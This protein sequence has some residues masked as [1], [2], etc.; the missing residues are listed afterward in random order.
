VNVSRRW[1]EAFLR[2]ELEVHDLARRLAQ[3][4]APADA[5]EPLHA[6]L[7]DIVI[8]AVEEVRPHPN[9]DR[10]RLCTVNDGSADRR[11]VVCGAP[12]V[13]AGAKY[14][15][16]PV[17]STLPGGLV[18]EKRKIRGELSEGMLCSARELGL[19]EDHDGILTLETEAAPG[20][21]FL[22]TMGL[23]DERLVLDTSPV[24]PDLLGH[25]GIARELAAAYR[26]TFRLPEIPAEIMDAP[27]IARA[28]ASAGRTGG[29]A[30]VIEAGSSCARFTGAVIRGVRVSPSPAWLRH[31]LE[32]VGV[33]SINNVVDA[34]NYGP[35]RSHRARPEPAHRGAAPHRHPHASRGSRRD[36]GC[37]SRARSG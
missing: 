31:R 17:G 5:I 8:A 4:G 12:N 1:L 29:I 3:L 2:R 27:A 28:T 20:T 32:S 15:F 23:R 30:V 14:P 21:H 34:T 33:R 18:I 24:R 13:V 16:A 25:K 10:L 35:C 37:R 26:T 36:W 6:D 19:G 22:D 7:H 11:H 9:A